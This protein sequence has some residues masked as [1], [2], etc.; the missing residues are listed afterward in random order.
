MPLTAQVDKFTEDLVGRQVSR[1]KTANRYNRWIKRFEAWR[2][3][4]EP[5]EEMLRDFDSF[6]ADEDHVDYPWEN[7][8]GPAAP[9]S[10]AYQTRVTALSANLLWLPHRYDVQITNEVQNIAKGEPAPFEPTILKPGEIQTIISNASSTC[11]NPDCEMAIRL[12]YDAIMRG[13]EIADAR[14]EDVDLNDGTIYV[15]AKKGSE[16]THIELSDDVFAMLK[17]HVEDHPDRKYL[18]R[19]S[20]DRAYTAS[21]WN[22]HFRRKHHDAGFHAF[23]RHSAVS[24]RLRRG[25]DFGDVYLRARHQNPSTTLK[26][27]HH[28]A[29]ADA[30]EWVDTG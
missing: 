4:G 18:F 23:A 1:E 28:V 29:V 19:N 15:R 3:G 21:A 30:P 16:P 10:Y 13:A 12:G 20:Y 22:Q 11:D 14:T 17:R 27:A 9:D 8:R 24:N 25:E 6:M 26:Y 2:G 5:D 7:T